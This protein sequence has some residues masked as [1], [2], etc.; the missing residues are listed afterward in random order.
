MALAVAVPAGSAAT[1]AVAAEVAPPLAAAAS[2]VAADMAT[3]ANAG[4]D[5]D[6]A[7]RA[8]PITSAGCKLISFL[9]V[10]RP[11]F[12][13]WYVKLG[14]QIAKPGRSPPKKL[15]NLH[16]ALVTAR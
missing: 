16:R 15:I 8:I 1:S 12:E 3:A 2:H 11:D 13:I 10:D 9:L 5:D 14:L 6:E 4:S 7:L